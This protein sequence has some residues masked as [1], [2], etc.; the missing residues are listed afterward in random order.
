[1]MGLTASLREIVKELPVFKRERAVG[2]STSAYVLSKL[3]VLGLI[4][5]YQ[6]FAYMLISTANQGGPRD[7]VVLGWPVGELIVAGIG[8]GLAAV[9][10]GL[11]CSSLVNSVA[12]A[13][14][15]LPILLICQLLIMQGGVFSNNKPVLYQASFVSSAGWGFADMAST[16]RLNDQQAVWNV[17]KQ[18]ATIDANDPK[19]SSTCSPTRAAAT[20]VGT[21]RWAPGCGRCSPCSY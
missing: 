5:V 4:V 19:S 9:A 10:L 3:S 18:V 1:M 11:L 8:I 16:A 20:R 6:A 14:A 13:I 21:T 15:L 7:A 17:A 12:A 2:L